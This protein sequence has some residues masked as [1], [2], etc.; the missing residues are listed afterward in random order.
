M[1]SNLYLYPFAF[2]NGL[3]VLL[4]NEI[5]SVGWVKIHRREHCSLQCIPMENRYG[6]VPYGN[7]QLYVPVSTSHAF[8]GATSGNGSLTVINA[9]RIPKHVFLLDKTWTWVMSNW[10]HNMKHDERELVTSNITKYK[11]TYMPQRGFCE[12]ERKCDASWYSGTCIL[13]RRAGDALPHA[14]II[15]WMS[16][17][18]DSATCTRNTKQNDA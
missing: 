6:M 4:C 15:S 18:H 1:K 5:M 12:R 10:Y 7:L 3:F 2:C 9:K 13:G 16:C 8:Q 14:I 11:N 17:N